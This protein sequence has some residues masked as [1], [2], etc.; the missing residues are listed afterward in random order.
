MTQISSNN[1]LK[2]LTQRRRGGTFALEGGL[3]GQPTGAPAAPGKSD[4]GKSRDNP[5]VF[6]LPDDD[7]PSLLNF[8]ARV[9][10]IA[11]KALPEGSGVI[12][13]I[14]NCTLDV[15]GQN[16]DFLNR[17]E[18]AF[19]VHQPGQDPEKLGTIDPFSLRRLRSPG[20]LR[21]PDSSIQPSP[22]ERILQRLA[23]LSVPLS[24]RP[25]PNNI[26]LLFRLF[27]PQDS[28]K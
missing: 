15:G 13:K 17:P 26:D 20:K 9:Q 27:P 6:A 22:E 4:P 24:Q 25:D 7:A 19:Y 14:E 8:L 3:I 12:A 16:P 11:T 18:I 1:L 5:R 21:A 28:K 2:S 23:G 10:R